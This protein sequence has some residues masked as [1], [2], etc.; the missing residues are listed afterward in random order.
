[1]DVV[2][3]EESDIGVTTEEPEELS[4][5][6]FPVDFFG[7]E[8]WESIREVESELSSKKTMSDVSASEILVVDTMLYELH[9]EIEILL[10]WVFRHSCDRQDR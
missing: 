5:D 6:P 3:H 1:M 2:L 10:F 7:G 4:D 9:T 8:E